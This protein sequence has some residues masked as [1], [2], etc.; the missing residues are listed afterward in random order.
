M[1]KPSTGPLAANWADPTRL[2]E[3]GRTG[4]VTSQEAL[5]AMSLSRNAA[6]IRPDTTGCCGNATVRVSGP[7][8]VGSVASPNKFKRAVA[9]PP[10]LFTSVKVVVQFSSAARCA[11]EPIKPRPGIDG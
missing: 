1:A 2:V 7:L 10:L 3:A 5:G 4:V 6:S 9:G 11:M 8:P